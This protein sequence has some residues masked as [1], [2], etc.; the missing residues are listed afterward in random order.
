MS[1]VRDIDSPS[2]PVIGSSISNSDN[3]MPIKSFSVMFVA[4]L[5]LGLIGGWA[6]GHGKASAVT[7]KN[8]STS[9]TSKTSSGA[10]AKTAGVEDLKT[11]KDMAEGQLEDGGIE[12]EGTWH[13]VRPGGDSQNVY[14]TSSTV[15]LSPY[16]GHKIRVHGQ[17]IAGQKAAWLMDVGYVEL[18]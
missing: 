13:L 15:D 6:L 11:F 1:L 10:L 4:A 8:S 2:K 5:V 3:T 16:I 7:E 12:G 9:T 17:T 14:L 18:L